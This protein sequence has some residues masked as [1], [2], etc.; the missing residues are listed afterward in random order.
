[1]S[2]QVRKSRRSSSS[3]W[4]GSLERIHEEEE[5]ENPGGEGDVKRMRGSG[6]EPNWA[7]SNPGQSPTVVSIAFVEESFSLRSSKKLGSGEVKDGPS[8]QSNSQMLKVGEEGKSSVRPRSKSIDQESC[9]R[10]VSKITLLRRMSAAELP[11]NDF[12]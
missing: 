1:M 5:E 12:K 9:E 4:R 7:K 8:R 10:P 6:S 2:R 11:P 3:H